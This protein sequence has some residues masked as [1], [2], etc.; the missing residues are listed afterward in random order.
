[1]V[2]HRSL[3]LLLANIK[4]N[5][6]REALFKRLR[7]ESALIGKK[8]EEKKN[9]E[10]RDRLKKDIWVARGP[11]SSK[12]RQ[13][14]LNEWIALNYPLEAW[15]IEHRKPAYGV[16]AK[17]QPH[18]LYGFGKKLRKSRKR[19]SRRRR[20]KKSR[21]LLHKVYKKKKSGS[22]FRRKK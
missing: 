1:M 3:G 17:F 22:G 6:K 14:R 8:A 18:D 4:A 13:E 19:K 15:E 5:Q 12:T 21:K 7:R 16:H 20:K 10:L 9:E 2:D 11:Y